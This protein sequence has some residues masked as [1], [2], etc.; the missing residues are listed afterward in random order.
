MSPQLAL[1]HRTQT[2]ISPR[3]QHSV[4][5][6]RQPAHEF[7]QTL[8]AALVE[9]P[10]LEEVALADEPMG[11]DFEP[12]EEERLWDSN[13]PGADGLTLGR[14]GTALGAADDRVQ[15][16]PMRMD[17]HQHLRDQLLASA[18]GPRLRLAA[19]VV[20]E[21]L[22]DDG[23]LRDDPMDVARHLS[24][25]PPLLRDELDT[26]RDHVRTLEPAGVGAI[27]LVDCLCLQ[28]RALPSGTPQRN[29][30]I[31]LLERHSAL[32]LRRDFAAIL[33]QEQCSEPELMRAHALIRRLD[34]RPG[35]S[36]RGH[37]TEFVL[38][39]VLVRE[40]H[41]RLAVSINP[42]L[43]SK[44]QLNRRY[45]EL[46]SRSSDASHG[47]MT[48][49]LQ[50]ARWMLRNIEQRHDTI[51]RIVEAIIAR[52][53]DFFTRGEAALQPLSLQDIASM[54]DLHES[55]VSRATG[56]KYVSSP[57]GLHPLKYFFSRSL[58][59]RTGSGCSGASVRFLIR[60]LTTRE[61]PA[62]PLSDPEIATQLHARGISVA[63]RTV[64]KYRN[65][66]K[67]LPAELRRRA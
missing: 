46:F 49:L 29:L 27:D 37:D 38:P 16:L 1:G 41:G 53:R 35:S 60:D 48:Q 9:N 31:R 10:F 2:S 22:D 3:L 56:N 26:A 34:P 51:R 5:L 44:I 24:G 19:E 42:R 58:P 40:R 50:E 59:R 43:N 55:T 12:E 45:V 63:R 61:D 13:P 64:T 28:L 36:I 47:T 54:V 39:D 23:Y 18:I 65:M 57:Q 25:L 4:R 11:I 15:R 20:V 14:T 17:L 52:Q 21:S 67:I 8:Q 66:L 62:A 32:L 6:L 33:S 30:A 7:E